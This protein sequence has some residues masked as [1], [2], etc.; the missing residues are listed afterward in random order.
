MADD[1]P[2]LRLEMLGREPVLAREAGLAIERVANAFDQA[3]RSQQLGSGDA[4]LE[5]RQLAVGSLYV[6]LGVL[7]LVAYTV[8]EQRDAIARFVGFLADSLTVIRE[9]R[10]AN[11]PP[12]HRSALEAL[13]APVARGH[14][15]Q[16]N[17]YLF[18][19]NADRIEIGPELAG[20]IMSTLARPRL[21]TPSV[22]RRAPDEFRA[23]PLQVQD[24]VSET[25]A[26]TVRLTASREA[27]PPLTDGTMRLVEGDWYVRA[28]GL[29]GVL[30]P[31][32]LNSHPEPIKTFQYLVEG[33]IISS[34]G[35]PVRFDV[36]N[37]VR[38]LGPV[39]S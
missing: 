35:R 14:A 2:F 24:A 27:G 15:T 17:L 30:L 23:V 22:M 13:A 8:W 6:D 36:R 11:V 39:P 3:I 34:R 19:D 5:L 18:G 38:N 25:K 20:T 4:R 9:T 16:V 37:L 21:S 31:A 28:E 33:A 1:A 29:D 10:T 7:P 26:E 12:A 32:V